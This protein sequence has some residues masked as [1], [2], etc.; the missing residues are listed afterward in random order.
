MKNKKE[1]KTPTNK[2]KDTQTHEKREI[3]TTGGRQE[4]RKRDPSGAI[5]NNN[6]HP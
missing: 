5:R 6:N 4:G 2:E 1:T 3:N